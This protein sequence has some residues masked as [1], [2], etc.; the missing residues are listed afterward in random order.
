M[1]GLTSSSKYSRVFLISIKLV[2]KVKILVIA[3]TNKG[4]LKEF[5]ELLSSVQYEITSVE[6]YDNIP[7]IEEAGNSFEENALLKARVVSKITNL[8]TIADD[9]GLEVVSLNNQPGIY[10]ARYAG[11][12]SSDMDNTKKLLTKMVNSDDREARFVCV[13]ALV[14]PGDTEKLFRGECNGIIIDKPR[15]NRGFGY[16]PVFM[17]PGINKTFAELDMKEKNTYSHR[18]SAIYK[19]KQYLLSKN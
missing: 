19:L 7:Y 17:I 13:I 18:A 11:E 1:W 8:P 5:R 14:I 6:D 10:S 3:T 9:S 15:G 2:S 16:D 12:K 4:K